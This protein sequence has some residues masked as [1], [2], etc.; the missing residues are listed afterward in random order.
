MSSPKMPDKARQSPSPKP[1]SPASD[2][3]P[4]V[5]TDDR[6]RNTQIPF[7]W[8]DD[9]TDSALGDEG[10]ILSS[11]VSLNESIYNYRNLHG[12]TY[13]NSSTT[14]YWG[15]NDDTQ[16]LGLDIAHH[17]ITL[18]LGDRLF[19]A[20]IPERP[21]KILDVGTGTGIWAIDMA[22]AYPSSEIIGT[23]ISPIQPVWVPQNLTFEIEDAQLD[24]TFSPST[25]DFIHMRALYGS[26]SDW[27]RL[28]RQA[29]TA[30]K[31]GGWLEDFEFTITLHS[32]LPEIRDDPDHIFKRWG[33]VFMEAGDRMG[34]SLRIGMNGRITRYMREAGFENITQ[35]Y[36]QVPVGGWSTD[37]TYKQ[38][39]LYNLTFMEDSLEGFALFLLREIMGW[40]YA[41]VQ[42]FLAEMRSALRNT[43]SRPYYLVTN[44]FAQKPETA[45]G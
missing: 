30:L 14:E 28:Y 43:K 16:N 11:T 38:I 35:K 29:Y 17:F 8:T 37:H 18:L 22:D 10:S 1:L 23:D 7:R 25:F 42:V 9:D 45:T 4:P 33:T 26:I 21:T 12:R 2:P 3:A 24:W 40:E 6:P 44:A 15:P 39:G 34:R 13:Q 19:E 27:P 36:Y 31:P 41:R 20:P 5:L 32:D